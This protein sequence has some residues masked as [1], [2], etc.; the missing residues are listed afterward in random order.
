MENVPGHKLGPCIK[1]AFCILKEG[2]CFF[3]INSRH[4]EF[5][6]EAILCGGAN[7]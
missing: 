5:K 1:L 2:I 6:I 7:V 3:E 4:F